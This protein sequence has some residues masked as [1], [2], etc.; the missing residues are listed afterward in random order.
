MDFKPRPVNRSNYLSVLQRY[1]VPFRLSIIFILLPLLIMLPAIFLIKSL[2]QSPVDKYNYKQIDQAGTPLKG[3]ITHI[4][5]EYATTVNSR[6][7]SV[8]SYNYMLNGKERSDEF[9]TLSQEKV[10]QMKTGDVIDVKAYNNESEIVNLAP[11]RFPFFVFYFIPLPLLL[12]GIAF[13]IY[14]ITRVKKEIT[15]YRNGNL[16]EA[17]IIT[18]AEQ[19]YRRTNIRNK[20]F[21]I[22]YSYLT[23]SGRTISRTDRAINFNRIQSWKPGDTIKIFVAEHD[24]SQSCLVPEDGLVKDQPASLP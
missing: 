13:G 20:I 9:K 8:I 5:T 18:I 12:A 6:H 15:L 7:P 14:L 21:N 22:T 3:R 19:I 11:F 17:K 10:Q 24:E 4:R 2:T 23:T 1:P 16:K